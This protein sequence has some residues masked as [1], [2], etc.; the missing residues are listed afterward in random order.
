MCCPSEAPAKPQ[1]V[2]TLEEQKFLETQIDIFVEINI[3]HILLL[4]RKVIYTC[5]V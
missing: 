4:R 5:K 2:Q 3:P 1:S